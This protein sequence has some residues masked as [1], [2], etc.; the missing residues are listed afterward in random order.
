MTRY[1]KMLDNLNRMQISN[2]TF[3]PILSKKVHNLAWPVVLPPQGP[4][5]E[6]NTDMNKVII[7]KSLQTKNEWTL[8]YKVQVPNGAM[9][10]CGFFSIFFALNFIFEIH[11]ECDIIRKNLKTTYLQWEPLC[12]TFSVTYLW[13]RSC[14][15][16]EKTWEFGI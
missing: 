14:Y 7:S 1:I 4:A 5:W 13:I 6:N 9:T 8:E 2:L 3:Q 11:F 15:W 10:S 12:I 16:F